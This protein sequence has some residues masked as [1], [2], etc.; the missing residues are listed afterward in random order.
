MKNRFAQFI[1]LVNK[2]DRQH[3]QLAYFAL[4]LASFL[5]ARAPSD[6]GGGPI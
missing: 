1:N 3:I 6:G 4:M 5:V 2:I